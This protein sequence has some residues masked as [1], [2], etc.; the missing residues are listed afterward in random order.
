MVEAAADAADGD[1]TEAGGADGVPR[2]KRYRTAAQV[3]R[4]RESVVSVAM[5]HVCLFELCH[6]SLL[7]PFLFC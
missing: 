5:R 3:R 6:L 7:L 2:D 4:S 1:A